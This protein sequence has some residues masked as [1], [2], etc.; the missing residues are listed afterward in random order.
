[1]IQS[2]R[3]KRRKPESEEDAEQDD[4]SISDPDLYN[5]QLNT[6]R[7][8]KKQYKLNTQPGLNKAQ[9]AEVNISI[10]YITPVQNHVFQA[11]S[12]GKLYFFCL[13]RGIFRVFQVKVGGGA[14]KKKSPE[15]RGRGTR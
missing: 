14:F 3:P 12:D 1:M 2:V 8:Y 15:R 13:P 10:T 5:L 11:I 7:K 6:L 4:T 9:L